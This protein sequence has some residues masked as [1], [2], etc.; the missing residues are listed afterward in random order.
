MRKTKRAFDGGGN[1]QF[2]GAVG[3]GRLE[4]QSELG[5]PDNQTGVR[6]TL[7]SGIEVC[8][9]ANVSWPGHHEIELM[10]VGQTF[11]LCVG[12]ANAGAWPLRGVKTSR[13]EPQIKRAFD[14][15]ALGSCGPG[16]NAGKSRVATKSLR[17]LDAGMTALSVWLVETSRLVQVPAPPGRAAPIGPERGTTP[18]RT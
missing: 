16:E 9:G 4:R 11:E 1:H 10:S 14:R 15:T 8:S 12:L 2:D 3:V 18:G 6:V 17:V 5:W 13:L 7:S